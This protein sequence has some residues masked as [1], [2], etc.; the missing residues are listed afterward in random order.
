MHL[1]FRFH[2]GRFRFQGLGVDSSES[3]G[4]SYLYPEPSTLMTEGGGE[5]GG[6]HTKKGP[7]LST[8]TTV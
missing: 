4:S 6:L 7:T 8:H 1:G 2:R 5:G 3:K